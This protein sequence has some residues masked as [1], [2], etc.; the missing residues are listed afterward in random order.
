MLFCCSPVHF[1]L[2]V[3]LGRAVVPRGRPA[4]AVGV[5]ASGGRVFATSGV[6]VGGGMGEMRKGECLLSCVVLCQYVL[7]QVR[8]D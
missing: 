1:R 2:R 4:A 6:A 7:F 5:D 3:G 8:I